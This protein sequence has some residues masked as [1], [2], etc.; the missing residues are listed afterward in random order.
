MLGEGEGHWKLFYYSQLLD[1]TLELFLKTDES[2]KL[3]LMEMLCCFVCES[4]AATALLRHDNLIS[5]MVNLLSSLGLS[6]DLRR[7][8]LNAFS[9]MIYKADQTEVFSKLLSVELMSLCSGMLGESTELDLS[10]LQL[11]C[12][13][14]EL[15]ERFPNEVGNN[16]AGLMLK[17]TGSLKNQIDELSCSNNNYVSGLSITI[18]ERLEGTDEQL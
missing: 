14:V 18:L 6:K 3:A 15:G 7:E 5:Y 2:W 9:F 12:G 10:I 13:L 1:R 11:V 4:G 8:L 17:S 16:V